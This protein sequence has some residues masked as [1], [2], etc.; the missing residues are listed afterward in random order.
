[1]SVW[2]VTG[3]GR[4][5]GREIALAAA[6]GGATIAGTVRSE[7]AA[8]DFARLVPGKTIPVMLDV[9]DEDA[10]AGTIARIEAD[11]GPID[12]LVN[13]AGRGLTGAIEESSSAEVRALFETN[14]MGPLAL[15]RAVLPAMREHRRGTI[16]NVTSVSGLAAWNGTGIYGASKF[17][18][19]CIGRT[20]AQE[21]EPLG[22]RV[23]NAA[24]GSLRTGFSGAALVKAARHIPDYAETAHTAHATL[25]GKAGEEPGDPAL[26]ARAIVECISSEN[27]PRLLLLGE[28]ALHYAEMEFEALNRDI[29]K[30]R[31]VTLSIAAR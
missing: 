17:A 7:E 6:Q 28:D 20:L 2:L 10:V 4:G 31:D 5:L 22:I 18:L 3:A 30:W 8:D 16:V 25:T 13:N 24:P 9:K 15:I 29:A 21:V 14:V 23:I 1:M 27:P 12:V 26:A 11:L 19:E